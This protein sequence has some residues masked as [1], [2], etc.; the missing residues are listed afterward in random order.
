MPVAVLEA[1]RIGI[2]H[3]AVDVFESD[4]LT[5][6]GVITAQLIRDTW[7]K[8]EK[9]FL[10]GIL[11]GTGPYAMKAV[12]FNGLSVQQLLN[13]RHYGNSTSRT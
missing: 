13:R 8:Q 7:A 9:L 1:P 3:G 12:P 5:S 4:F 2:I 6:D 10:D 11:Y